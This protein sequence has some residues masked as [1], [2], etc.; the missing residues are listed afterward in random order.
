M[1]YTTC[2]QSFVYLCKEKIYFRVAGKRLFFHV[3]KHLL[4]FLEHGYYNHVFYYFHYSRVTAQKNYCWFYGDNDYND[5][6]KRVIHVIFVRSSESSSPK[7]NTSS[8]LNDL[9]NAYKSK[10]KI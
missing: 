10:E 7:S 8:N 9:E 2:N 5:F 4:S 1:H 6:F 3:K